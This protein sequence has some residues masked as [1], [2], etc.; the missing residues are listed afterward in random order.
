[1]ILVTMYFRK[2]GVAGRLELDEYVDRW[3]GLRK[4]KV[5]PEPAAAQPAGQSPS[6]SK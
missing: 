2:E 5:E 1:M 4:S 3:R 6:R